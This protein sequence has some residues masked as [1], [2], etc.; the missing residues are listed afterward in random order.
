MDELTLIAGSSKSFKINLVDENNEVEDLGAAEAATLVITDSLVGGNEVLLRKTADAN[1]SIGEGELT[2]TISQVEADGLEPG[3][4]IAE[5]AIRFGP[6]DW[7]HSDP[8]YVRILRSV[9]PHA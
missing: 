8:F 5:V 1:L 2:A 9:A 3:L 7:F 4:Y 6:T